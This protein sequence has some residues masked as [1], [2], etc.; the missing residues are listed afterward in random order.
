MEYRPKS[1]YYEMDSIAITLSYHFSLE[2]LFKIF[3]VS[4]ST[5]S[6]QLTMGW[7]SI[8]DFTEVQKWRA[9]SRNSTSKFWNLIFSQYPVWYSFLM[10]GSSSEPKLPVSDVIMTVKNW[11]TYN[12]SVPIQLFCFP[13]L[14]QYPITWAIQCF[15]K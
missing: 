3:S 13:L 8:F 12:N 7:L 15:I 5:D 4:S 10:L 9:F 1:L 11:Y 2:I 14:V 6:P